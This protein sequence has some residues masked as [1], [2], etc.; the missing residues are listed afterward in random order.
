MTL[1]QR[2]VFA[3]GSI[4]NFFKNEGLAMKVDTNPNKTDLLQ[5]KCNLVTS[6]LFQFTKPSNYFKKTF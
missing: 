2:H 1:Y 5:M 6:K 3:G 4:I